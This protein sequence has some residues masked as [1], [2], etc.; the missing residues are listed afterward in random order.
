MVN[1]LIDFKVFGLAIFYAIINFTDAEILMKI[2]VFLLTIGYTF[3][4][5]Y[6][7]EK[8]NS[9]CIDEIMRGCNI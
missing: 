7:L 3:R 4:R 5:W 2:I 9:K 6:L 8:N 1:D